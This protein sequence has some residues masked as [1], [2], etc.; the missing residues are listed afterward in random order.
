MTRYKKILL[1]LMFISLN[2]FIRLN[3]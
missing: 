3:L 2:K 1:I